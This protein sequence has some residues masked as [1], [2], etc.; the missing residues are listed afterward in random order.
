[1]GRPPPPCCLE[2]LR[3][4]KNERGLRCI[5]ISRARR[6][7]KRSGTELAAAVRGWMSETPLPRMRREKCFF[8]TS[9]FIE[10]AQNSKRRPVH[11]SGRFLQNRLTAKFDMHYIVD[12]RF[13][14]IFGQRNFCAP[15]NFKYIRAPMS[16]HFLLRRKGHW[17]RPVETGKSGH[18]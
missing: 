16:D 18:I 8:L 10:P 5:R 6:V 14:K 15:L 12:N 7:Q 17:R 2:A 1:M 3:L 11:A 4:G 9:P 13:F